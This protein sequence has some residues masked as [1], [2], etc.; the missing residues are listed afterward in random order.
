MEGISCKVNTRILSKAGWRRFYECLDNCCAFSSTITVPENSLSEPV[1]VVK[2]EYTC[3]PK[4]EGSTLVDVK[5]EMV[6]MV[7]DLALAQQATTATMIA[8]QVLKLTE[9][10]YSGKAITTVDRNFMEKLVYR[11]RHAANPDWISLVSSAPFRFCRQDDTRS[12]FRFVNMVMIEDNLEHLV[13]FAHP[14]IIFE[15]GDHP[16][17][18]FIDCTFSIV[19]VFFSQILVLMLYFSKY[20]LYVPFY[21]VLMTVNNILLS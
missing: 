14:D 1:V 7:K 15:A 3:R 9:E 18:G 20:D 5:Q 16:L 2:K 4:D 21:F 8:V 12:F 6:D 13:G 17:H 11:T 10:K 19:P